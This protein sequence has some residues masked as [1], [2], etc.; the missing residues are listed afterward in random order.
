MMQKKNNGGPIGKIH[1][2]VNTSVRWNPSQETTGV[3]I[4]GER[5][6]MSSICGRPSKNN[7]NIQ[8][9]RPNRQSNRSRMVS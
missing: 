1:G 7:F 6:G 5:D 4:P 3:Q 2:Y 8:R 9:I